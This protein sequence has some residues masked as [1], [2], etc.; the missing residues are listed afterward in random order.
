MTTLSRCL[1]RCALAFLVG[2][3]AVPL[4][5]AQT[6]AWGLLW[7]ACYVVCLWQLMAALYA[8]VAPAKA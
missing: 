8:A 1:T 7:A 2:C 5:T 6:P 3:A 4:W